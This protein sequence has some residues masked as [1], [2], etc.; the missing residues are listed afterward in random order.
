MR[1]LLAA[2]VVL[3]WPAAL[4]TPASASVE[5]SCSPTFNGVPVDRIDGLSS[6]LELATTDAL[7]FSGTMESGTT[8]ARVSIVAGPVEIDSAATAY[9]TPATGF[10]ATIDLGGLSP[11]A[12]GLYRIRGEADGCT[13]EAWMRI[14]GRFPLATLAGLTGAGVAVAGLAGQLGAIASRRRFTGVGAALAGILTG[15]GAAVTAQQF[16][17]LQPSYPALGAC[18]AIAA[19]TGFAVARL[20]GSAARERR[21]TRRRLRIASTTE[22]TPSVP[23]VTGPAADRTAPPE[24]APQ[25][26]PEPVAAPYWGYVL[27]DVDVFDMTDHTRIVGVLH[28][29]TWYLVKREVGPWVHIAAGPGLDGW[30]A[31]HALNRQG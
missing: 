31:R 5:G 15:T 25:P 13:A 27:S 11:Y 8:T 29:G 17:V 30:A 20:L 19:L 10:S 9:A 1:R 24:P 21:R 23:V 2:L 3:A 7:V 16:G 4:A 14:T 6:P 18:I 28:P 12:V 22:T 26:P